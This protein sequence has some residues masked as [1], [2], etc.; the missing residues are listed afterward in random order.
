ML[1]VGTKLGRY[2][3]RAKLG[4]GG[5]GEVYLADDTRLHRK[6]A[7]KVLPADLASHRDRM[8]RFEQ[9]AT[10]AAALNHPNIATIHE[11]SESA[12]VHFI[13]MEFIDGQTLREKIHRDHTELRKLLR[14]LQQ[15]A[16]GLA[17]AHAAGIVHRDLKPDNVMITLDGYAKILDFGLAKLT[18][19]TQPPGV[20]GE[21]PT[22]VM[23]QPLSTPGVVMG[24]VGYMSPEQA[25]GRAV[26][27]RSD[28]FS[29][30]CLL[31]EAATGQRAFAS[32]S[33]IDTLHKIVHA[34]VPLVKDVNPAAPAD[35]TRIVRR[36]LAK[37]PDERYQ[38]IKEAAIELRDV[39][40][41]LEGAAEFD[42]TVPP[43]SVG[44]ALSSG[45]A[46]G[47]SASGAH[48]ST[49]SASSA[50]YIT[51]GIRHHKIAVVTVLAV[52]VLAGV[53]LV[54]YLHARNTE[55]AIDS[56]AVNAFC[57]PES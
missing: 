14:Y 3:I 43:S 56:I 51:R 50:E 57:E 47:L 18:E 28:I 7:L 32:E 30:G 12:G 16:E 10:A 27:H 21:A 19:Q 40:R 26:D 37:D 17:K 29:F 33:T 23:R 13:A 54:A 44:S 52:L 35:L 34:P 49:A 2:E 11:I 25:Q 55:V 38:S 42:T 53:G 48:V 39:R 6:V 20:E 4:A 45:A 9:E 5:M 1:T 31:Y 24:T 22:A 41:E 8:R 15:V 46:V 36:C